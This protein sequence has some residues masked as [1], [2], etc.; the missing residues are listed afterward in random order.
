MTA[1]VEQC[2]RRALA[3]VVA[4]AVVEHARADTPLFGSG[5]GLGLTPADAVAVAD[6]V[7]RQAEMAGAWCLL[8]DADFPAASGPS[9]PTLGGLIEVAAARW[10]EDR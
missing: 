5:L 2:V 10:R 6:A 1:L 9:A 7:Q 4:P 8:E 3:E